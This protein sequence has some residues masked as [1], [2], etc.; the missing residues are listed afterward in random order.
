[1]LPI[2]KVPL[3]QEI[4]NAKQQKQQSEKLPTDSVVRDVDPHVPPP[5][6]RPAG[7]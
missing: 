3:R 5:R 1:M 4:A 6:E 2:N 7:C